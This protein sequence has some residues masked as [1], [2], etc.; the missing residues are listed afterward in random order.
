VLDI[1][2]EILPG[3]SLSV[4]AL[5]SLR[6]KVTG[7][8]ERVQCIINIH[9][10]D[11]EAD[12]RGARGGGGLGLGVNLSTFLHLVSKLRI[13]GALPLLALFVLMAWSRT[14]YLYLYMYSSLSRISVTLSFCIY[15]CRR[16]YLSSSTTYFPLSAPHENQTRSLYITAE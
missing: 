3:A 7:H 11:Q 6:R 4:T 14:T 12:G 5:C 13:S 2:C 16:L 15:L 8:L 1:R 10:E 9:L